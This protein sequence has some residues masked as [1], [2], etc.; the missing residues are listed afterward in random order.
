VSVTT[1]PGDRPFVVTCNTISVDGRITLAP[2]VQL[3]SGDERWARIAGDSDPY[4]WVRAIHDPEVLL[5]GS[6]SFVPRNA[7]PIVYPPSGPEA[8]PP[9]PHGHYLPAGVVRTPQRRW[10]AIVDGRGRV[11]LQF[12][13]WPDPAWAGWHAL[14]LTSH[15]V[16]P[17]HLAW[18]RRTGVPY[19]MAGDEHVDLRLALNL[20][21]EELGVRTVVCTGGGLLTGALLRMGLIDE[22][23]LEVLPAAIGGSG[24]PAL[25]DGE[26]LGEGQ[27]PARLELI[28]H[29]ATDGGHLRLRYAVGDAVAER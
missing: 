24:T 18:M 25:F 23:D 17:A 1:P 6:G 10:M 29:Q 22:I 13:E 5:E 21:A 8:P 3:I 27:F 12:T 2:G 11:Q 15:A 20:L 28:S 7:P 19:L 16:A 26:P 14:V 4:E 9:P